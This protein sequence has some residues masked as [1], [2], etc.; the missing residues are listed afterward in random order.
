M[1]GRLEWLG[2]CKGW[3]VGVVGRVVG[4]R[5]DWRFKGYVVK[6]L[7]VVVRKVRWWSGRMGIERREN[8]HETVFDMRV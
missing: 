8:G 7:P 5:F 1:V 4:G 3:M 2:G 6:Y